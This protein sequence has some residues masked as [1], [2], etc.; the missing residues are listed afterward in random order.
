MASDHEM[1]HSDCGGIS[2]GGKTCRSLSPEDVDF[3]EYEQ[4]ARVLHE[5]R[6]L[7]AK[8]EALN[9][10]I[11]ELTEQLK[12][13]EEAAQRRHE[14]LLNR[15]VSITTP[16]QPQPAQKASKPAL[17]TPASPTPN[18]ATTKLPAKATPPELL[19]GAAAP[20]KSD[21]GASK[22]A[23]ALGGLIQAAAPST[24]GKRKKPSVSGSD[25]EESATAKRMAQ[26]EETTP[27]AEATK[28]PRIPPIILRRKER[29]TQVSALLRTESAAYTK[30]KLIGD[31]IA[32]TA[33]S[34]T[35]YRR[36]TRILNREREE[37]HTYSLQ[38]D[39]L[40]RAVIRGIPDGVPEVDIKADLEAQ[41]LT[42]SS[43][44][45]MTSRK[46]KQAMPLVLVMA[47]QDQVS[48]FQISRCCSLVVRV[49]QQK[50]L[51]VATQCHRC[52]RFGHGQSR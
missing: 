5:K 43:V 44:Q 28:E 10:K 25:D 12:Q 17:P 2:D 29:W 32:V 34:A 51:Q 9:K 23:N 1:D 20:S 6:E 8:V 39:R 49:E 21:A 3:V 38:E 24:A 36:I 13:Q 19:I 15:L 50:A 45:R 14:E 27:P 40:L 16:C 18:M 46:T 33:A 7:E 48:I 41:G 37:Y 47:P 31:G 11:N 42:V 26:R 52:Q 4:Y 22:P 30:A 35:D